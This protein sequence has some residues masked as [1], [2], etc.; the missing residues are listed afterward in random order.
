LAESQGTWPQPDS[1]CEAWRLCV[2]L[3]DTYPALPKILSL[4]LWQ[5]LDTEESAGSLQDI[6]RHILVE[7]TCSTSNQCDDLWTS[8]PS[9]KD[10]IT[11]HGA[12]NP[13]VSLVCCH[14]PVAVHLF[15]AGTAQ[16]PNWPRSPESLY[17]LEWLPFRTSLGCSAGLVRPRCSPT[18]CSAIAKSP[19][20]HVLHT[21]HRPVHPP[22]PSAIV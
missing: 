22:R 3:F 15:D 2:T 13:D 14:R 20:S 5:D 10:G 17:L 11:P 19:S 8:V 6:V 9:R 7:M 18:P 1:E 21:E 12:R 4:D 16:V